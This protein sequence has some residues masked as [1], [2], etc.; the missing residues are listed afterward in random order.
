[1]G[2]NSG[3]DRLGKRFDARK[4]SLNEADRLARGRGRFL[5]LDRLDGHHARMNGA[6]HAVGELRYVVIIRRLTRD[7]PLAARDHLTG[8]GRQSNTHHRARREVGPVPKDCFGWDGGA[9][10]SNLTLIAA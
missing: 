1:M 4:T 5:R 7:S 8:C 2:Y 6:E 9:E 10:K 3:Q